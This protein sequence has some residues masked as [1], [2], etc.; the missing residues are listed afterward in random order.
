MCTLTLLAF[1]S[2]LLSAIA[3][4][5]PTYV[6]KS[7]KTPRF[8]LAAMF[9]DSSCFRLLPTHGRRLS[10]LRN[11]RTRRQIRRRTLMTTMLRLILW[12]SPLYDSFCFISNHRQ[13]C[14]VLHRISRLLTVPTRLR[15]IPPLPAVMGKSQIKAQITSPNHKSFNPNHE[16]NQITMSIQQKI[17]I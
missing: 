17:S 13:T 4:A 15:L 14:I 11:R 2:L 6:R 3:M 9:I 16:S 1:T 8:R 5:D 10:S 7:L 12:I